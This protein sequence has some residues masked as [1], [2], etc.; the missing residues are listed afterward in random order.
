MLLG[1][2]EHGSGGE[3]IKAIKAMLRRKQAGDPHN[4]YCVTTVAARAAH[5]MGVHEK[6]QRY[7]DAS[8]M[9]KKL[10]QQFNLQGL[11]VRKYGY[12][13]FEMINV[14]YVGDHLIAYKVSDDHNILR[15][16]VTFTAVL[17]RTP[18]V[19]AKITVDRQP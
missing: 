2:G 10:L 1:H 13:G 17:L 3:G 6:A 7:H 5:R 12:H 4:I 8:C 14:T 15:S 19:M 18:P 16:E 9:A 11:W